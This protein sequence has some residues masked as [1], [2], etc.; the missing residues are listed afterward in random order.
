MV[1]IAV[2]D[3]EADLAMFKAASRSFALANLGCKRA[4]RLFGCE[5]VAQAYQSGLLQIVQHVAG[6]RHFEPISAVENEY[7]ALIDEIFKVADL[8]FRTRFWRALRD[9]AVR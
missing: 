6:I 5:V 9:P 4:A 1:A 3:S 2:G 7:D 8:P